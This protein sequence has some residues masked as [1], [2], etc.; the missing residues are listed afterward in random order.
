[1]DRYSGGFL[2]Q[3]ALTPH[4]D[5]AHIAGSSIGCVRVVTVNDGSGPKPAYAVWK[6]PAP[7]AMSDNFWQAGSLLAH[8]DLGTGEVLSCILGTGLAAEALS[9][10]PT[11]GEQV[12]GTMLPHWEETLKIAQDAHAVFPEF[13]ICGFDIAVTAEGPHILECNDNPSHMLYQM[14]AG[15]GVANTYLAPVW[16][17]V[18]ERQ[19]KQV[20]RL[21]AGAKKKH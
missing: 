10:H 2:F 3:D 15:R 19:A 4:P 11:S 6:M 12:L 21:K 5:M 8:L 14:A 1:M 18:T 13:G 17:A 7:D 16:Q 20:T 9:T